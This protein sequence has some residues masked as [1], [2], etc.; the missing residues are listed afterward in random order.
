MNVKRNMVSA[1][2]CCV[3]LAAAGVAGGCSASWSNLGL[4]MERSER[5]EERSLDHVADMPVFVRTRNGSVTLRTIEGTRASIT[6]K[7]AAKD[8][9]SLALITLTTERDAAGVLRVVADWPKSSKGEQACSIII[10]IPNAAGLDLQTSNGS[11]TFG[12]F[13]G[14]A[15]AETSNGSVNV[16]RHAGDVRVETSNGAISLEGVSGK[17]HAE[18]S[19]GRITGTDLSGPVKAETSNG[20]IDI[21]LTDQ[22]PGPVNVDSSNSGVTVRFG[23][24]F[25]G[26]L[27]ASCSNGSIRWSGPASVTRSGSAN[28]ARLVFPA[29]GET[30]KA[31]T[32]NGSIT[33][34]QKERSSKPT[35]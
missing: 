24:G 34:E 18:T 14:R 33:L 28:R 7:L 17:V 3:L 1:A 2:M 25:T 5:T 21:G 8:D 30:S 22:N 4:G 19:N 9:E 29:K 10:A 12:G 13:G 27:D 23:S 26:E 35:E 20:S 15:K 32:S 31:Q 11:I 6:A 16:S